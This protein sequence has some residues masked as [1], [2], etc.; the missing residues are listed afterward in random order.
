MKD[1]E[2][3]MQNVH[4]LVCKMLTWD[5]F[6]V[7]TAFTGSHRLEQPD[8][9]SIVGFIPVYA[10]MIDAQTEAGDHDIIALMIKDG[11]LVRHEGKP[12]AD[13]EDG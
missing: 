13:S 10:S 8:D 11:A 1:S 2:F 5:N 4:F 6:E 12:N 3:D 7:K 9:E